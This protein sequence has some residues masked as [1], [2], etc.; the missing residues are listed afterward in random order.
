MVEGTPGVPYVGDGLLLTSLCDIEDNMKYRRQEVLN[1]LDSN[2]TVMSITSFPRLGCPNFTHPS[3]QPKP[4][5]SASGSLF[6][7]DEAI[8]NG[9]PRFKTLVKNIRSR[10]R[11]KVIINLPIYRDTLTP[12]PFY[13]LFVDEEARKA[14]KSNHVYMDAMGFG[15]GCCCL[16]LT[17]QATH[18]EEAK[19]L[20]DQL[21][22]LTPIA[23]AL[24]A[25][26]PIYRGLLTDRDCRWDVISCSVD[27]RTREES[28]E[29]SELKDS[30]FRIPKSRYD[31]ISCYLSR[32]GQKYNDVPLVFDH[33]YYDLMI[34]NKVDPAVARHIAHLFIRDPITLYKEKLEQVDSELDHFEN[35]QSTNWQTMR[36][37]P[38]PSV[39]SPIGWRVEFR[40][41]EAQT[42]DFENAAFVVFITLLSRVI[43]AYKLNFLMPI[44][45]V[46][47]NMVEAQKRDAVRES[48]FWFRSDILHRSS[49]N[50]PLSTVLENCNNAT[51]TSQNSSPLAPSLALPPLVNG[52]NQTNSNILSTTSSRLSRVRP[53]PNRH[54]A[55]HVHHNN[56]HHHHHHHNHNHHYHG[57]NNHTSHRHYS[58]HH[59]NYRQNR[60]MT[61][62]NAAISRTPAAFQPESGM[63]NSSTTTGS[64]GS[65]R[66]VV[67]RDSCVK[68]TINDIINGRDGFIGVM[69]IVW[70]YVESFDD[71]SNTELIMKIKRYLKLISDR[72][73]LKVKTTARLMRDFV[74]THPKYGHD[75]VIDDEVAYDLL[76]MMDK[77]GKSETICPELT[78]ELIGNDPLRSPTHRIR[79]HS[80]NGFAPRTSSL[81]RRNDSP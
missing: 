65:P 52:S 47:E 44:S 37:K 70:N 76:Q 45:L 30:S 49:S 19:V 50:K 72:A 78:G 25:A 5:T 35:I 60:V 10:R 46:D 32:N 12:D 80:S 26:S 79:S 69:P 41:L 58:H 57:H 14:S 62:P 8:Y 56:L 43:L 29:T 33:N 34:A 15:M 75:S 39:N 61:A 7:P 22:P 18:L 73:S 66:D 54:H 55:H 81:S 71:G 6:F 59:D 9:H 40:P 28:S 42:S 24:S 63:S 64:N 53:F 16:Q 4:D 48:K 51:T 27:D 13:E 20:Y 21:A 2:E 67:D 36:F 38:P 74:N 23:L 11:R 3:S 1:V 17:M 68:M 77:I 31:S